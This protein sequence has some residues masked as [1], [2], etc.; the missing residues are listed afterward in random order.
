MHLTNFLAGCML[1]VLS[2]VIPE[3]Y[4]FAY[5]YVCSWFV[6][7]LTVI[8]LDPCVAMLVEVFSLFAVGTALEHFCFLC[9]LANLPFHFA[10]A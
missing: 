10:L 4:F 2:V 9:G 5:M 3:L 1:L 6:S 7:L 8:W